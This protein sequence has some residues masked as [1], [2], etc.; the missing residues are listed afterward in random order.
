MT[1]LEP[2]HANDPGP[3]ELGLVILIFLIIGY[4]LLHL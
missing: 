1:G 4:G 2:P 3:K